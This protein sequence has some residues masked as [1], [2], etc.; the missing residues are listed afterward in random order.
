MN[1]IF[2]ITTIC[3][4]SITATAQWKSYY[5]TSSKKEIKKIDSSK[6]KE[7]FFNALKSKS[8]E[9]YNQ[10]KG[11][12]K[13]CIK[14]DGKQSAPYYELALIHKKQGE[15]EKAASRI[16]KAIEIDGDNRWF[17]FLYAEILFLKNNFTDA[18]LQYQKLIKIEP[19]NEE[20]Y[21]NLAE[22][23]I[24]LNNLPK[25]I[26]A[27]D[28][29]Q[30]N[31][32]LTKALSIQ[33]HKLYME[34]NKKEK[35]IKELLF[36]LNTFPNDIEILEMLSEA[37][38]LND[39]Q[40]KAFDIFKQISLVST[41]NGRIHL[42]LADYYR[43]KGE[44]N[45]SYEELKLAFKSNG[46]NI[47]TK[48]SVLL[49]YYRLIS[50]SDEMKAQAY[51]LVDILI[52]MYPEDV[53]V[54]TVYADI[55]YTDSR[56]EE[57][58]KYYLKALDKEKNRL[59][60][61]AQ[62]LFI[63]AENND[64]SKMIQ[65]SEEALMYFPAEPLFYYFNGISNKRFKNYN[66]SV[67]ALS[68]GIEFVVDN[69]NLLVEFYSS[70]ADTYHALNKH[71]LSDSLYEQA[72]FINPENTVV[73]NNYAYY[74]SLRKVKLKRAQEMS[75]KSNQIENNNGTYQDTYAWILFQREE[76]QQAKEWI[77]KSL[78]NGSDQSPVV[79][80]HYGD[81]LF[82]LG[83]TEAAI[84][85]WKKARSL[86]EEDTERLDKKITTRRLYE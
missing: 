65:T 24:Y 78:Q 48:I 80:E 14:I 77:L 30:K 62:L 75:Y 16:K 69:N 39:Q 44:N 63:Y 82:M 33:K 6:F 27:Y 84:I 73:L 56:Y 54:T 28:D 71:T 53:K 4:F 26:K 5:P 10:A 45:K 60:T 38:L 19:K 55:L 49:S 68:M 15:I 58:K 74:L 2:I 81:I 76:Y 52:N 23:Y 17:R 46:L 1:R 7:S 37:Y 11:L 70:L 64:F 86:L 13:E 18:A 29:L 50:F 36:F 42:T 12:F 59:S 51:E 35:A 31:I 85:Q 34:I 32:G 47:D 67:E 9:E 61:W 57:A 43:E 22:T 66:K 83:Q 21:F 41:E 40:E 3:F 79:V 25:A 20:L 72:L 8:I